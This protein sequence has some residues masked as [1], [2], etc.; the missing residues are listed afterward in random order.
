MTNNIIIKRSLS[1]LLNTNRLCQ[2]KTGAILSQPHPHELNSPADCIPTW[3]PL[4]INRETYLVSPVTIFKVT[5]LAE[6]QQDALLLFISLTPL[7]SQMFS[8]ICQ[9]SLLFRSMKSTKNAK[10]KP[11]VAQ[12][13]EAFLLSAQLIC[14]LLQALFELFRF[15]QTNKVMHKERE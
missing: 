15:A 7:Y 10:L 4:N 1:D 14:S 13:E 5:A 12:R 11:W 3:H 2:Y 9:I 8:L 6:R